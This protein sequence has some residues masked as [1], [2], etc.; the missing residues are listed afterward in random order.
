MADPFCSG[1]VRLV[2]R[3]KGMDFARK[4]TCTEPLAGHPGKPCKTR[5]VLLSVFGHTVEVDVEWETG[6]GGP[7]PVL[8]PV[9][10]QRPGEWTGP[11]STT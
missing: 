11:K 3:Y 9:P 5:V 2:A 10:P 6:V 4:G 8:P 1:E 7:H